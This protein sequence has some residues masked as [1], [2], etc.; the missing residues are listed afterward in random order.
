MDRRATLHRFA[1]DQR[2]QEGAD[3]CA[4]SVAVAAFLEC[5][6]VANDAHDHIGRG[7][8]AFF[9]NE[10]MQLATSGAEAMTG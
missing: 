5:P 7:S 9:G 2:L 4:G 10:E 8:D 1:R 6:R 3:P